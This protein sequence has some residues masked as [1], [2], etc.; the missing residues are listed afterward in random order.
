M[1]ME[2]AMTILISATIAILLSSFAFAQS[3]P[4][5]PV[6]PTEQAPSTH[7]PSTPPT[8]PPRTK[9]PGDEVG[10][11]DSAAHSSA[12][13]LEGTFV[14]T[15]IRRRHQYVLKAA[16]AEYLLNDHGEAKRYKG[17]LV[18]VTGKADEN[19]VINVKMIFPTN[20]RK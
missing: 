8:F 15:I 20:Q 17:K 7:A 3:S 4:S 14:G 12:H 10:N 11:S 6:D 16:D 9:S 2:V 18:K 19:H 13:K 5:Q 1:G